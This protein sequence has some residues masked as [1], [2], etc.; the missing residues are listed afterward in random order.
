M[1]CFAESVAVLLPLTGRFAKD[2]LSHDESRQ[3]ISERIYAR[4]RF[5]MDTTIWPYNIEARVY[6]RY[7]K[8]VKCTVAKSE[9][10][11]IVGMGHLLDNVFQYVYRE[12]KQSQ[13]LLPLPFNADCILAFALEH[14]ARS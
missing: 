5:S 7:R 9:R 10:G 4:P 11:E 2:L 13:R 12:V 14:P 3:S 6:V 1:A 8:P